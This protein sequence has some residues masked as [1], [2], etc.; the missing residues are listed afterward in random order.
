[1]D[2]F[3][4]IKRHGRFQRI[5]F[6]SYGFRIFVWEHYEMDSYPLTSV[7]W[8]FARCN[9]LKALLIV[10]SMNEHNSPIRRIHVRDSAIAAWIRM[11]ECRLLSLK[12]PY[13]IQ[14]DFKQFRFIFSYG[15]WNERYSAVVVSLIYSSLKKCENFNYKRKCCCVFECETKFHGNKNRENDFKNVSCD[16]EYRYQ[17]RRRTIQPYLLPAP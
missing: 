4:K 9:L 16:K 3:N 7:R 13:Q 15:N 10:L 6:I 5:H 1:M 17:T 8:T 14:F 11:N 2:C 12:A